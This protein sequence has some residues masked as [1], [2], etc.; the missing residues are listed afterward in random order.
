MNPQDPF[1]PKYGQVPQ[2]PVPTYGGMPIQAPKKGMNILL[3]PFILTLIF[4]LAALGFGVWAFMGM[5][6]YKNNVEP[7][8]AQAVAIAEQETATA[9]DAEFVEKEKNPLRT[10]KGPQ[11]FGSVVVQYP[12]TW[13]AFVT[14][15]DSNEE[16]VEGYFH[17][18]YVPG[19]E[20][21]TDFALRIKV[22]NRSYADE[23]KEF[24]SK[25]KSGAIRISPY[26]A[27][28][29]PES[30]VGSRIEGEINKGQQVVMVMFPLR[31]KT[32][33]ISTES[34]Q[35]VKDFDAIVMANFTFV[36]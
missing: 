3:I 12:K 22:S 9:K 19:L 25:T 29:L 2:A 20:S 31:D 11:A 21:G 34:A 18:S 24:E 28:K 23:L 14:E 32:I 8:I 15:N 27:P 16:P 4:L 35:F 1:V 13:S 7:K 10:Y 26:R 5:Q 36:P 6:D 17:P 30:V 33:S